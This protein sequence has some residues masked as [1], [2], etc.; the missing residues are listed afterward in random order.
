MSLNPINN[1]RETSI[2]TTLTEKLMHRQQTAPCGRGKRLIVACDRRGAE[3]ST[4][5]G[6]TKVM[7]LLSH[8]WIKT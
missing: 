2:E 6:G 7:W 4:E 5:P 1:N 8:T 3:E